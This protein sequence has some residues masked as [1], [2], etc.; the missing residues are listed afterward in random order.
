MPLQLIEDAYGDPRNAEALAVAS[1]LAYA[2][3]DAGVTAFKEQLGLDARLIESGHTQCWLA[4]NDDHVVCAFRG[5]E[6]PTSL[7][8]LKD[9]LLADAMNL[10]ILPEGRMGTDLAAAGVDAR[11]HKGFVDALSAIWP[12]VQEAI[13][14]EMKKQDRPLWL[15]GHSLGGALALLATWLCDRKTINVH[16]VYTFGAPMIGNKVVAAAFDKA[17][18]E[19][20]FR[21]VNLTDPV[22]MLPTLS[23]VANDYD[24]CQKAMD[25]GAAEGQGLAG[26]F[27]DLAGKTVGGAL[28]G[29]LI[30]DFWAGIT[31]RVA[32]HGLDAYRKLMKERFGG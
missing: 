18:P 7:D 8:G 23:L 12:Q 20:I 6:A 14:A 2:S 19:K 25:V 22:P 15:T 32:A 28:I 24:H 29:S 27:T 1:D 10:L 31:A 30:N 21:F 26:L 4:T 5:T 9:W 11:F 17:F 3:G 16:Q 13:E